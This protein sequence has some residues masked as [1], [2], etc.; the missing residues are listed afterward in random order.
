MMVVFSGKRGYLAPKFHLALCG[1]LLLSVQACSVAR[2]PAPAPVPPPGHP[3]PYKVLGNWYQ[4]LPH[5]RD[6]VERGDASWYGREFHGRKT[7]SGETYD[8][9]AITAAHKT[10]PLGTYVRVHNLQNERKLTVK[11]NDRGPFVRGRIID[12]SY[13]AARELGVVGPG[14]APVEIVALGAAV[15]SPVPEA[16]GPTYVPLDYYQGN[17]T[18]QVGAFSDRGNAERL[19]QKLT[20]T[21]KNA[22]I[23]TYHDGYETFY[24]VRVGRCSTLAQA[25]EYE[26]IMI[27]NGF[28]DAFAVAEDK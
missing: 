12:L 26:S 19:Q 1:L 11:I 3:K 23:T 8:M 4:P 5:A 9:Y 27:R 20:R 25:Q 7:S 22:H 10:L 16:A 28:A 14:T 15:E 21:Y 17:F 24:R 6:F 18:I 2:A 13:T